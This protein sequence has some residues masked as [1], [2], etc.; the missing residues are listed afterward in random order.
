MSVQF[1]KCHFDGKPVDPKDLDQVRPVLAPYGPDGEGYI[2]Q[3]NFAIL[4]RAFP[5]TKESRGEAQPHI[6]PSGFVL[7]WDGRLDN[8][9]EL[10]GQ[11]RGP[12]TSAST[13]LEIVAAAYD[14]YGTDAFARLIGDWAL[15][16]WNPKDRSLILAKDFV[17]TRHLYYAL[18][19][20]QVT[21]CSILDPL[22]LFAGRSFELAE[23]YIAGWLAFFPAAH[24]TP[25][26]GIH[27]VPPS[28]FVCLVRAAQTVSKYW[29]F[30]PARR[31][32][33]RTDAEYEEHFRVA[34]SESV[35][36]RLRSCA[37]VLA[38]LSGGMDSSSIVCLA[39]SLRGGETAQLDT[40]SYWDESEPNCD[41]RAYFT[42]IEEKRRQTGCHIRL[43]IQES[44]ALNC[45]NKSFMAI[46][47]IDCPADGIKQ[48][49]GCISSGGSRVMLSG[50]G[51][52]EALGGVP[53]PLPELA[54]LLAQ[55]R[56]RALARQLRTWALSLRKPWLHLF[57]ETVRE[58]LPVS[59]VSIPEPSRPVPWLYPDF[60]NRYRSALMPYRSR[61]RLF[62]ALPSFQEH[63][64]ILDVLRRQL[65][66]TGIEPLALC[67]R[68]YPYLDRD[69][70]E[71]LFAIPAEQ[72]VRPG[73]RRS[74]MRRALLGI[75]PA[76]IVNRR[77]KAFVA[78][79]PLAAITYHYPEFLEF[80][81]HMLSSSLQIVNA[82][83]LRSALQR[84]SS[85]QQVAIVPLLR[86]L[87]L[88]QWLRNLKAHKCL[89]C[90]VTKC[91]VS[92]VIAVGEQT[93]SM[94]GAR[95]LDLS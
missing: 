7:T 40:V 56:I 31:I 59:L 66:C 11:L 85:G 81:Q 74:L 16:V 60:A 30:D 68:R 51:G 78:H 79:G 72:L 76:E 24:L 13:D 39:D 92:R 62:G 55:G 2:C 26:I 42:R 87:A 10:I 28:S 21:W 38:E 86:M 90:D 37:P 95:E 18:E 61:T 19:K 73:Q 35:R 54:D 65:A 49:A 46:P 25:Y 8:R 34:F 63:L 50:F 52:D 57:V 3:D 80:S 53:T 45:E 75:V 14:Q 43:S 93:S 64:K 47:G 44:L 22:V 20:D 36:R 33:Y 4:Y 15:S 67:E 82:A 77:R 29:D 48:L 69:L 23:E 84:A 5:T 83:R 89:D 94:R 1:G 9:E 12:L 91:N 70:L 17:G 27:S 88:E 6:A 41:D 71:F 58:F 32:R